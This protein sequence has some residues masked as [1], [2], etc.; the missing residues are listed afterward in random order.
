MNNKEVLKPNNDVIFKRLFGQ[1]GNERLTKSFLEAILNTK[2]ESIELG[3]ETQLLPEKIDEKL[4]ILDVRVAL[5]DG[6]MVDIEM[7]NINYGNIEKRITY[8]LNQLYV[9]E[10]SKGKTYTKLNKVIAIGILNF[11]YFN[12]IEEYH[13]I[14][15]MTEQNNSNKVLEEQEIHFIE[16]PKFL[17]SNID[18]NRKL[19]Q[20]LLFIDFSRKELLKM[21]EKKN[22]IIKEAVAEYEYLTGDE[23]LQRIAFL[24]RK[25]ELDYNTGMYNAKK[26]GLEEGSKN[27]KI[28]IAKRLLKK[29][30]D[31]DTICEIAELSKEKVEELKLKK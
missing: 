30:F 18:T 2:I 6:T 22:S 14:W 25:Y 4:G 19:D 20:W 31:I 28:K 29:N 16:L 13:T 5:S 24:K 21:S 3:K 23:D 9:S 12:D 10:L 1:V 26:C 17:R 27:E 11:D 7:Q 8:Y 15:K